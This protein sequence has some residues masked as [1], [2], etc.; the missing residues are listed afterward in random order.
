MNANWAVGVDRD[1]WSNRKDLRSHFDAE[2]TPHEFGAHK[3]GGHVAVR[4]NV[5]DTMA[6]QVGRRKAQGTPLGGD[7][8][9]NFMGQGLV[10]STPGSSAAR[11]LDRDVRNISTT[12]AQMLDIA[13]ATAPPDEVYGAHR[14]AWQ[15]ARR[16]YPRGSAGMPALR[17]M[18]RILSNTQFTE[19]PSG[20]AVPDGLPDTAPDWM[21]AL[22]TDV[23]R[24][25]YWSED[26]GWDI[27]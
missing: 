12:G 27:Y 23:A 7:P 21:R 4:H 14:Q 9:A 22:G 24:Q 5:W 8:A 25:H 1:A 18:E 20:L 2:Y 10:G 17:N 19:R 3:Q 13:P 16:E 15:E 11:H 6:Q 26:R